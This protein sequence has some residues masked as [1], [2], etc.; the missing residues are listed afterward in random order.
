MNRGEHRNPIDFWVPQPIR[1]SSI[2]Y[3]FRCEMPLTS[4]QKIRF[5]MMP[6][7]RQ[8]DTIDVFHGCPA[9]SAGVERLFFK[10]RKQHDDQKKKTMEETIERNLKVAINTKLP[11]SGYV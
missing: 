6:R 11:N 1:F 2:D 4:R 7:S 5:A 3:A 10:A 9:T 8:L